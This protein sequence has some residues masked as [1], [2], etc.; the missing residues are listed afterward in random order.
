MNVPIQ[1]FNLFSLCLRKKHF[2]S[3]NVDTSYSQPRRGH[4]FIVN[5]L[6]NDILPHR[7]RTNNLE[8]V[9]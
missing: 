9:L 4:M 6:V 8:L 2:L 3:V 7:G 5:L 1:G